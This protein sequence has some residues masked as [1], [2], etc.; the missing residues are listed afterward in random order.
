MSA[1]RD[2][3]VSLWLGCAV[4]LSAVREVGGGGC[5]RS[6][7]SAVALTGCCDWAECRLLSSD[8]GGDF[9]GGGL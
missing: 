5:L 6:S 3:T 7:V 8:F 2:L 1:S 4:P 9:V